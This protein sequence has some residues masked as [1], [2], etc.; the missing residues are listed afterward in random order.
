M[1]NQLNEETKQKISK[2]MTGKSHS[3]ETKIKQSQSH[4]G[5]SRTGKVTWK[6]VERIRDYFRMGYKRKQI[7]SLYPQLTSSTINDIIAERTWKV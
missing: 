3:E 6:I 7:Y 1:V 2:K 5:R 4:K